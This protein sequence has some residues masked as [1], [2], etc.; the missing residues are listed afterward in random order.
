MSDVQSPWPMRIV[1]LV[2]SV[3]I[4]LF[5]SYLPRLEIPSEKSVT[6]TLIYAV[7]PVNT[8]ASTNRRLSEV[9]VTVRGTEAALASVGNDSIQITVP[10]PNGYQ[11][12]VPT[13]VQLTAD[14]VVVPEGVTIVSITPSSVP[15][16]IDE[17]ATVAVKVTPT[18][19]GEPGA[20]LT[21]ADVRATAIPNQVILS[22]PKSRMVALTNILTEAIDLSGRAIDFEEQVGLQLP[23][24]S[25]TSRPS[26]VTVDIRLEAEPLSTDAT[27]ES[28]S[29][30]PN[31]LPKS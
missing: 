6:V 7:T 31:T 19:R 22:G 18:F 5:A 1:A 9:S 14:N 12:G 23:D 3:L 21:V 8:I 11:L 28:V 25:V 17:L 30:D 2:I 15:V 26:L 13:E 16:M 4:W 24:P 29:T 27:N 10:L 20:G